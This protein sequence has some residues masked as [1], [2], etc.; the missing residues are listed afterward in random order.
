MK[1]LS[2]K[3]NFS[4]NQDNDSAIKLHNR[5][6]DIGYYFDNL[7]LYCANNDIDTDTI[8]D[9]DFMACAEI[10]AN[11]GSNDISTD[12]YYFWIDA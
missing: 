8:S 11:H 10:M 9:D 7:C 2:E 5:N 12:L 1:I 6:R 3:L 4:N